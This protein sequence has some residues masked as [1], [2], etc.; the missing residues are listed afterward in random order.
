MSA[1][2]KKM[3]V[4]ECLTEYKELTDKIRGLEKTR[5]ELHSKLVE[6]LQE[7]RLSTISNE[8]YTAKLSEQSREIVSKNDLPS[9]IWN[10]Y[11]RKISY[12]YLSVSSNK[13]VKTSKSK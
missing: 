5:E 6:Y 7:K 11:K 3:T 4:K 8:Q 10:Q 9:D 1:I 12:P 13:V 2:T